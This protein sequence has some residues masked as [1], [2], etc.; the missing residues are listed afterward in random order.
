MNNYG[1]KY[2]TNMGTSVKIMDV[3]VKIMAPKT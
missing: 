3:S 1:R 2:G